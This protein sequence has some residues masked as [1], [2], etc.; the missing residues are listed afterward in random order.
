MQEGS[1]RVDA[2]VNLHI[3]TPQGKIATPIVE[4]KNLNSFRF[5]ERAL[6][7]EAKRQYEVWQETGRRW[8]IPQANPR[9]GRRPWDDVQPAREGRIE[10]L[11]LLPRSRSVPG[12]YAGR[13]GR[14]GSQRLAELPAA[15]RHRLEQSYSITPYDSDVIVAQG[16]PLVAY[17]EKSRRSAATARRRPTG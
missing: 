9:L 5:I 8:A 15:I 4:I 12:D 10:R 13:R 1:L 16:L 6:A 11:S 17:Y 14:A 2:N 7:Y 3:D